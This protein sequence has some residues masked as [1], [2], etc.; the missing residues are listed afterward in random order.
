MD[1]SVGNSKASQEQQPSRLEKLV[2]SS[3][4]F[5]F[6][7]EHVPRLLAVRALSLHFGCRT[8]A[9]FI[10]SIR[11]YSHH[12]LILIAGLQQLSR[13]Q[14]LFSLPSSGGEALVTM[15][16]KSKVSESESQGSRRAADNHI[17]ET[18]VHHAIHLYN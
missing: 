9:G 10:R 17:C 4:L 6:F 3:R 5:G 8:S 15:P 18:L 1:C 2:K 14:H 16:A 13:L 7:C 12:T 11:V